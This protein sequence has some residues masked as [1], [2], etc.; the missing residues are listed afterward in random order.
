[1]S[2]NRRTH[3]HRFVHFCITPSTVFS[4]RFR[5]VAVVLDQRDSESSARPAQAA[6]SA[7]RP[8]K[9]SR[10]LCLGNFMSQDLYFSAQIP[11]KFAELCRDCHLFHCK[12][13][14]KLATS[15]ALICRDDGALTNCAEQHKS[16]L[17]KFP[18]CAR[19]LLLPPGKCHSA[20]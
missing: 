10:V 3:H 9:P 8:G 17:V 18:T 11:L 6:P 15:I 12:M 19:P 4:A 2:A 20:M 13:N 16:G 14:N 5:S 7:E 1:M